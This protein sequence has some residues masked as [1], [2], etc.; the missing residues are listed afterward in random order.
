MKTNRLKLLSLLAAL[1][2]GCASFK[3]QTT[4]DEPHAVL[5]FTSEP[6]V[7][8]TQPVEFSF[9]DRRVTFITN[10]IEAEAGWLY[11]LDGFEVRKFPLR[12]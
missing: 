8:H 7:S 2:S 1:S 10:S 9:E 6:D 5:R 12:H 4:E 3:N 11:E